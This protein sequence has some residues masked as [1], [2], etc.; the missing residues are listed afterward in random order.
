MTLQDDRFNL[1]WWSGV[2]AIIGVGNIT[3]ET[4][5]GT[6]GFLWGAAP[7]SYNLNSAL[8]SIILVVQNGENAEALLALAV[9]TEGRALTVYTVGV[10]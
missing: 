4:T 9:R 3:G 7:N 8:Q 2:E 10:L 5:W 6:P 1:A